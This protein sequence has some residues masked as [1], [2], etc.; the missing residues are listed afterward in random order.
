MTPTDKAAIEGLIELASKLEK[1][2]DDGDGAYP[3]DYHE[4]CH[5]AFDALPALQRLLSGVANNGIDLD[6]LVGYLMSDVRDNCYEADQA[7]GK[8]CIPEMNVREAMRTTLQ[9]KLG[10]SPSPHDDAGADKPA[11]VP[12]SELRELMASRFWDSDTCRHLLNV[13]LERHQDPHHG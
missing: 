4:V 2:L 1:Q 8:D 10:T 7:F 5:K 11:G 6:S 3:D 12:V 9:D 13:L